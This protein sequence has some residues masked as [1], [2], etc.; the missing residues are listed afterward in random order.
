MQVRRPFVDIP[1]ANPRLDSRE[2]VKSLSRRFSLG[3][4]SDGRLRHRDT[5]PGRPSADRRRSQASRQA[6]KR[7][8]IT[9]AIAS[10]PNPMCHRVSAERHTVCSPPIEPRRAQK[11]L[12]TTNKPP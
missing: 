12:S 3:F 9:R 8:T 1:A 10:N 6:E 5:A 2:R 7:L 4:Y 11:T